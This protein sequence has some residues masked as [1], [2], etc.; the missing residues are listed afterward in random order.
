[1][2][3][4]NLHPFPELTTQRCTLRQV[5]YNDLDEIL[6]LRSD[7]HVMRYIDKARAT[8]LEEAKGWVIAID[9]ALEQ[10][11]GI[12]W[13]ICLKGEK[14]IIGTIGLW[15]IIKEHYRA[16]I[17]YSLHPAY[18]GKG[19][20]TELMAAVLPYGFKHLKLHSIE[21]NVNPANTASIN[22]LKKHGFIQEG[23]F[24]ENFYFNGQF[25]D[26]AIFSLLAP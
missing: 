8:T 9:V 2:L 18:W 21:A 11:S 16:E 6:F 5:T 25:L 23:Y 1:M 4:I 22:L 24:K 17:G 13:G 3:Q 14:K 7:N 15:R 20:M 12:T 19:L 10:S 26:S